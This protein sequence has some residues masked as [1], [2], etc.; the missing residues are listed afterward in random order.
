MRILIGSPGFPPALGGIERF[1]DQLAEGLAK[2]GEDVTVMTATPSREPDRRSF[3]VVRRPGPLAKLGL[4][5]DCDVFF[6]A[7]V[8][9]KDVWPLMLVRR[10]WVISHHGLYEGRGRAG[11]LGRLKVLLARRSRTAIAVSRFV[12]SR[13]DPRAE[14]IPN[15]Y[16]D[17]LFRE[18]PGVVRDRDFVFVG[19]LVS[20]KGVDVLLRALEQLA[21]TERAPSL[22]IIGDGPESPRLRALSRELGLD[23]RVRFLGRLDGEELVRELNRHRVLV[24]PSTWEEPF[25]IV[26]LEGIACGCVVLGTQGGGLPEAIGPCGRTVPNGDAASL[27]RALRDLAQREDLG[28]FLEHASAH[29]ER[30]RGDVVVARYHAALREAAAGAR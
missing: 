18:I 9:L 4:V 26:A 20:D 14:V 19:R 23:G 13:V 3:R 29:L 6:Q 8:S 15:P 10:P 5:R 7:N 2:Q 27:C 21:V 11:L 12:A 30:H 17:D 25:G 16:R 22:T 24:V 28:G 1:V